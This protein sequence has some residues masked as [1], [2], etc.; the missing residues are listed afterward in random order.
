[1]KHMSGLAMKVMAGLLIVSASAAADS[2]VATDPLTKWVPSLRQAGDARGSRASPKPAKASLPAPEPDIAGVP[3]G[4]DGFATISAFKAPGSPNASGST[5]T[6]PISVT[7]SGSSPTL[8]VTDSGTNKG[9]ESLITNSTNSTSALYGSTSGAG[10]GVSGYNNGSQGPAGKF[11]ITD[12]KSQNTAVYAIHNGEGFV[13]F[14]YA[15]NANNNTPAIGGQSDGAEGIGVQGV[16]NHLGVF[17]YA[18][19]GSGVEGQADT[20]IG[21]FGNS[22]TNYGVSGTS[23]DG[24]GV[25][26][27]STKSYGV[28]GY[29]SSNYAGFFEGSVAAEE[30]VVSAPKS[31]KSLQPVDTADLL[32]RLSA[33]PINSWN[34]ERDGTRRHVGAQALDFNTSFELTEDA[35]HVDLADMVGVS[36]AAIQGLAR[37]L[38]QKDAQLGAMQS[39]L[40]QQDRLIANMNAK[41]DEATRQMALLERQL[42]VETR[43]ASLK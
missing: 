24:A 1:M 18:P 33:L 40:T 30:Y 42:T 32:A 16:A 5:L 36:I 17:G 27:E 37:E 7:Y 15:T 6:A 43:S 4:G 19:A 25:D 22:N 28:Y 23:Y 10:A 21:V 35:A 12:P 3:G 31:K 13:V 9:V 38:K 29:S 34:T 39:Q 20:G 11:Q 26:G 41:V 2:P 8:L 14:G